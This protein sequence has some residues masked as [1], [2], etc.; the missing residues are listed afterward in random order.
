MTKRRSS[1][2]QAPKPIIRPELIG[3]SLLALALLT[4]LSLLAVSHGSLT[5]SWLHFL[6]GLFGWG[7]YLAPL[8]MAAGGIWLLRRY[9]TEAYIR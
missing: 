8:A 7:L 6:R 3:L 2:K 9:A 5:E 1:K 4:L